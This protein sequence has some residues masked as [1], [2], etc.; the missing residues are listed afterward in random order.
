MEWEPR[1]PEYKDGQAAKGIL[2]TGVI[3][4]FIAQLWSVNEPG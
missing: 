1:E 2:V 3:G 4:F